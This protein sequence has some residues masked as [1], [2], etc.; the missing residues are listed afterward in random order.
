MNKWI[1]FR[2]SGVSKT[3]KTKIWEVENVSGEYGIG[4]I[5][6]DGVWRQYAFFPHDHTAYTQEC[7]SKIA[8]FC[9]AES[10]KARQGWQKRNA[11]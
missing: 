11:S 10:K 9:G 8:G 5:R 2:K 1:D 4:E 6:W 3:G 7:L